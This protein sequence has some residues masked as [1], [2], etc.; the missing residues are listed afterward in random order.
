MQFAVIMDQIGDETSL[1]ALKESVA[2]AMGL[3]RQAADEVLAAATEDSE[4][5]GGMRIVERLWSGSR[6]RSVDEISLDFRYEVTIQAGNDDITRW[7]VH[8]YVG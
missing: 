2:V 4:S 5:G 3:A 1:V 6:R 7:T 8:P